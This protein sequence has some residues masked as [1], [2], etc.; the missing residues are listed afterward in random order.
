[1]TFGSSLLPRYWRR[2]EREKRFRVAMTGLPS[3]YFST[4]SSSDL[5]FSSA[6]TR[7]SAM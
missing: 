7:R 6:V 4:I 3:K 5:L 2:P 1:M